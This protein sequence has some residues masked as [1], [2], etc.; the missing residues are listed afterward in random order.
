[1]QAAVALATVTGLG[2]IHRVLEAPGPRQVRGD[3]QRGQQQ[4][5]LHV[6]RGSGSASRCGVSAGGKPPSKVVAE[7][8]PTRL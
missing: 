2:T 3:Q 7:R 6:S 5:A 8:L 1:M 4:E